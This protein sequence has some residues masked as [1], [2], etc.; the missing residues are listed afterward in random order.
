[1]DDETLFNGRLPS[2][3]QIP[4]TLPQAT[5]AGPAISLPSAI[6]PPPP[7]RQMSARATGAWGDN[8]E[9]VFK[10]LGRCLVLPVGQESRYKAPVVILHQSDTSNLYSFLERT[11]RNDYLLGAEKFWKVKC[12]RGAMHT[13]LPGGLYWC[14]LISRVPK[15]VLRTQL[16]EHGLSSVRKFAHINCMGVPQPLP[17]PVDL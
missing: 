15:R 6:A 9:E 1:M 14:H 13:E 16:F 10:S 2:V 4:I 7:A 3:E 12:S 8:K 11:L 5:T 17:A